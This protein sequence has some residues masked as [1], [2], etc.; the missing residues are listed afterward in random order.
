MNFFA[1]VLRVRG[2][3]SEFQFRHQSGTLL[4]YPHLKELNSIN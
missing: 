3:L 4:N 2:H 1:G